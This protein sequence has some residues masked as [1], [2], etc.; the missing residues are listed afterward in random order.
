MN[1]QTRVVNR[2]VED[3]A[4]MVQFSDGKIMAEWVAEYLWML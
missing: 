1:K 4:V 2:W 3:N